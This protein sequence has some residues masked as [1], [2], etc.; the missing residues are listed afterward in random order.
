MGTLTHSCRPALQTVQQSTITPSASLSAEREGG[1]PE[2]ESTQL[3]RGAPGEGRDGR[4]RRGLG[5]HNGWSTGVEHLWSLHPCHYTQV[6]QAPTRPG[7]KNQNRYRWKANKYVAY[8]RRLMLQNSFIS[9]LY[10]LN[11]HAGILGVK[12]TYWW[13]VNAPLSPHRFPQLTLYC[14]SQPA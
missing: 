6:E 3:S 13:R 14:D 9:S 7:F 1:A 11:F 2:L 5:V 4:G 10:W 12:D 8:R